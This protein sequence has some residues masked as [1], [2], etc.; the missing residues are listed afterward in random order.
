MYCVVSDPVAYGA[1]RKQDNSS[2]A[3]A[4]AIFHTVLLCRRQE[5]HPTYKKLSGGVLAWLF[6][7]S[8]V[9]TCIWPS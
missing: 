5:G 8:E 1:D 9:Q 3:G 4:F 6:V 2:A 7:L